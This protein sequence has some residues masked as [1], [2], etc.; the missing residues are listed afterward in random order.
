MVITLI[1]KTY[2]G[3]VQERTGLCAFIRIFSYKRDASFNK[4]YGIFSNF[5]LD[6]HRIKQESASICIAHRWNNMIFTSCFQFRHSKVLRQVHHFKN[7][8]VL[9]HQLKVK[10]FWIIPSSLWVNTRFSHFCRVNIN[11]KLS[12]YV[13][14]NQR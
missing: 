7:A 9:Q 5:L 3:Q 11:Q 12:E 4:R 6:L 2:F 14:W 10:L 8:W 1:I 13:S